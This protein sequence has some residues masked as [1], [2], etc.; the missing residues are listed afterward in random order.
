MTAQ[1][2][3]PASGDETLKVPG[4]SLADGLYR[5]AEIVESRAAML[6][7]PDQ[8]IVKSAFAE[9]LEVAAVLRIEAGRKGGPK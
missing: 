6:D 5:A 1:R 9:L 4:M 8:E 7:S 3:T 2:S